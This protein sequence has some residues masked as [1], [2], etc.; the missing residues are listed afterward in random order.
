[1]WIV[2]R[3]CEIFGVYNICGFCGE[4][5]TCFEFIICGDCVERM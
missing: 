5:L 4:I 1:V 3:E 2:W